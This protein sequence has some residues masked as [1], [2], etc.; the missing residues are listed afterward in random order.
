MVFFSDKANSP[1]TTSNPN[2][3]LAERAINRRVRQSIPIEQNDLPVNE[4]YVSQLKGLGIE[5]YFR[6]K[7]MNG[8]LVQMEA[9]SVNLVNELPFVTHVEYVAPGAILTG[10]TTGN[11]DSNST[12]DIAASAFQ[13]AMVGIDL[14][15]QDGFRGEDMI[16]GVFDGGF[17]NISQLAP[18]N[19]LFTNNKILLTKNFITNQNSVENFGSHGTRVLSILA[20]AAPGDIIGAAPGANYMLFNTEAPGEFRVEEYNWLFAAE[21]A[22]SA[23]VDIIS[24]SL[25][26]SVFDDPSMD[27]S[28]E[29]MDGQ[30]TVITRASNFAGDKGIFLVTSAGNEGGKV[31]NFIT[32]PADSERVLSIGAVTS[33]QNKASFSGFGPTADGRIK[34]NVSALGVGTAVVTASGNIANQ[35]GT[36]FSAPIVTG[37]IAGIWQAYPQLSNQELMDLIQQSADQSETPDNE[38]GY[39]IPSYSRA[40]AIQESKEEP[41]ANGIVAYPNPIVEGNLTLAFETAFFNQSVAM[42]LVDGQGK[43]IAEYLVRPS[44]FKNRFEFNLGEIASGLY[45]LLIQSEDQRL[46]KKLIKY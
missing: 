24:T 11:F 12:Q 19:H 36:S 2:T 41:I 22:D 38:L 28:Y 26:Y 25:G 39:G 16:I 32:A 43:K 42:S 29:D 4:T 31:W 33:S 3:Y 9:S 1:H 5:T 20:S 23:G 40:V 27:Y 15:H 45:F 7:W 10:N 35:S 18:L 37:L 46:V 30:T 14:M 8:V 44:S 13:N 34:P 6:T 17:N 21:M